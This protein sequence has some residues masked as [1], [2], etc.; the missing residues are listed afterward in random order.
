MLNMNYNKGGVDAPLNP[1]RFIPGCNTDAETIV[2][3]TKVNIE[4]DLPWLDYEAPKEKPLVIVA[5]GVSLKELWPHI[6]SHNGDILALNN[7]YGF[8]LERGIVPNY[9]MLMDA[10][11]E[12]INFLD[13]VRGDVRHFIAAQCHP[14]V[15]DR[16]E[17]FNATLYLTNNPSTEEVVSRKEGKRKLL[18]T[19]TVGTV[20][21]RA[22]SLAYV[23]GYKE[24]HLYGYDSSYQDGQHHAYKQELNDNL[25]TIDIHLDNRA[26]ITTPAFAHQASEFCSMAREMVANGFDIN[27]HC[28]GLLPDLVAYSNKQGEAPLEVREQEKYEEIWKHDVYRKLA[29]GELMVDDAL[30]ALGMAPGDSVIDFGCGTG[31]AAQKL[32]TLGYKVTG[33]DFAAN[34]LDVGVDIDF[35]QACLWQLPDIKADWGYCTDVM[36]HIPTEKVLDVVK[37]I[38]ERSEKGVYFNIATRDDA[39]GGRI[40]RKLHMTVMPAQAWLEVLTLFW[41]DI[42]IKEG[43]EDVVFICKNRKDDRV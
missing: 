40:G 10:R 6:V 17:G 4:R 35:K 39:L 13:C 30:V 18:L 22:L 26:Y 34:C 27:L 7:A 14:D 20:G 33:V 25:S 11:K 32:K 31:R 12:N 1:L 28:T 36:E 37:G 19:G 16:L 8:L 24:L 38:A 9:F 43:E 23:L 2:Q 29:P 42:S 3:H 5:G 21:I 15:F 41:G